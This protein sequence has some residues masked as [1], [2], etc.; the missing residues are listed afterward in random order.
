MKRKILSTLLL[1]LFATASVSYAAVGI[2]V[3]GENLGEATTIDLITNGGSV[4][5]N[6]SNFKI[7][8]IGQNMI[9]AGIANGGATSMTTAQLAVPIGYGYVRKAISADPAY[10]AGT[11]ANGTPGQI[12]TIHI[13]ERNGSGT[14]VLTPT[15]KTGFS[16]I[17]FD[18]VGEIASFWYVDDTTGWVLFGNTNATI[19]L[20]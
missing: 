4:D 16:T 9:A 2:K 17:T 10:S 3:D 11:M 5:Q 1:L 13:T 6:G 19:A 20:P 8:V 18:A 12:L 15:T 7:P 14:F